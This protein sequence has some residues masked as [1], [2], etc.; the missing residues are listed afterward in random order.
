MK[1]LRNFAPVA[2]SFQLLAREETVRIDKSL[3]SAH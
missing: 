1:L 2:A 3:S